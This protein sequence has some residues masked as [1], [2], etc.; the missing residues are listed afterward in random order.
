MKKTALITALSLSAAIVILPRAG[1]AATASSD[2]KVTL[3]RGTGGTRVL[4]GEF[5][6]DAPIEIVWDTLTDYD[7]FPSF[8]SSVIESHLRPG[9]VVVQRMSGAV[10]PFRKE[11]LLDLALDESPKNRIDFQDFGHRSFSRY[12]G[13]WQ[14]R[15]DGGHL[16]VLYNLEATPK[17]FAPGLLTRSAF[18][19]NVVALL[20]QVKREVIRRSRK[21][22]APVA[23]AVR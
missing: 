6:V 19:G 23:T 16:T 3:V 11:I 20:T 18:R 12:V 4:H 13:S 21:S 1:A 9:P 14:I 17:F 7:G 5:R 2:V 15:R 10:G 8:V 22:A